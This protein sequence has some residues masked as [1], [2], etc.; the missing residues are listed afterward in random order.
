MKGTL[1]FD[2]YEEREEFEHAFKGS[3]YNIAL[4]DLQQKIRLSV[5]DEDLSE[6]EKEIWAK[7]GVYFSGLIDRY[8][9]DFLD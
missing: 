3:V 6:Q 1:E 5:N 7:L 8:K 2:L 4:W 9:I